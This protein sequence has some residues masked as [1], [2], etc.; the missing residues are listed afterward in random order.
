M[1]LAREALMTSIEYHQMLSS[2]LLTP[3]ISVA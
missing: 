3:Q 1:P 2:T